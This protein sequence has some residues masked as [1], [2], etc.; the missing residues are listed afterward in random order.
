MSPQ[1]PGSWLCKANHTESRDRTVDCPTRVAALA[2][3]WIGLSEE[4]ERHNECPSR[5]IPAFGNP[6]RS[7]D[8][9]LGNPDGDLGKSLINNRLTPVGFAAPAHARCAFIDSVFKT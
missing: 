5:E 3:G 7:D 2:F 9:G 4:G 1:E 6:A 8:F